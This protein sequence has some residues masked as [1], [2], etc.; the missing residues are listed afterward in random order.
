MKAK[1]VGIKAGKKSRL[2]CVLRTLTRLALIAM[3][4]TSNYMAFFTKL[5]V[6][7]K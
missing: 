6:A 7:R 2:S 3:N 4:V 1:I 5:L